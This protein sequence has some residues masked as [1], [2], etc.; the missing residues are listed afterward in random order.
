MGLHW[1]RL[2]SLPLVWSRSRAPNPQLPS[3]ALRLGPSWLEMPALSWA[4]G[5]ETRIRST[6]PRHPHCEGP[7]PLASGQMCRDGCPRSDKLALLLKIMPFP[8]FFLPS[9]LG[10]GLL[11]ARRE[12]L[13]IRSQGPTSPAPAWCRVPAPASPV[14]P[15]ACA[16]PLPPSCP[17]QPR[18][19]P[20][21]S[22]ATPSHSGRRTLAGRALGRQAG[23]RAPTH[24]A[25]RARPAHLPWYVAQLAGDGPTRPLP[26]P[27]SYPL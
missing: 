21:P 14:G 19:D 5:P 13:E 16:M 6:S 4:P 18:P 25:V 15:A 23:G 2:A 22:T 17:Q 26:E 10:P 8:L 1:S 9:Y 7:A 27:P 20:E 12:P 24:M 11:K 3:W